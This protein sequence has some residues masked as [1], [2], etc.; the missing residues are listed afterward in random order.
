M[1]TNVQ[2]KLGTVRI[3]ETFFPITRIWFTPFGFGI[4]ATVYGPQEPCEGVA[5]IFRTDGKPWNVLEFS[6]YDEIT[7]VPRVRI[8]ELCTLTWPIVLSNLHS[9]TPLHDGWESL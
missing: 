3:D 5:R 4:E 7:R 6:E 8:G 9:G 2:S 1:R